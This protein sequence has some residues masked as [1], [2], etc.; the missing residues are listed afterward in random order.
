MAIHSVAKLRDGVEEWAPWPGDKRYRVSNLGRVRGV[1]GKLLA[2]RR[3]SSAHRVLVVWASGK[4]RTVRDM[5]LETFVGRPPEGHRAFHIDGDKENCA[6]SNLSYETA[7]S[8][9][10][11]KKLGGGM[12][13]AK[14]TPDDVRDILERHDGGE[15]VSFIARSYPKVSR[16]AV[17]HAVHGR[18]WSRVL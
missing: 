11:R 14:L 13:R 2:R 7:K 5:V 6:L 8:F 18:N 10:R 3:H 16:S 15:S 1:H 9:A 4:H 12:G 17:S